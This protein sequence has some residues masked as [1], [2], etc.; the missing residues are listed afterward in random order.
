MSQMTLVW[1]ALPNELTGD[2]A[3]RRLRLS[4]YVS[5]RLTTDDSTDGTLA[6][7]PDALN[8]PSLL[9]PGTFSIA[10]SGNG[11]AGTA[12]TVLSPP[13]D[14]QLW[15]DLFS[16]TTRVV[17]HAPDDLTGRPFNTYQAGAVH[18]EVRAGHQR[19]SQTSPVALPTRHQLID[20]LPDL[21]G[22]F[23][24]AVGPVLPAIPVAELRSD[25]ELTQ[26]Q[27]LAARDL[28][29]PSSG[30]SVPQHGASRSRSTPT[31]RQR[32]S[33]NAGPACTG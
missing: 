9:Q 14:L 3:N 32:G 18:D 5:M 30:N 23:G 6:S 25:A 22:A 24:P 20:A 4:A 29:R 16:A 13:P 21:H 28:L 8:W 2:V 15:Q 12:A 1:T 10:V 33:R 17:S 26:F 11:G 31:G 27:S 19:L 7:F